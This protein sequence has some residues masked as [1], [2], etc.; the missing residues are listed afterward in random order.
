M[1][2]ADAAPRLA[3]GEL[4]AEKLAEEFLSRIES[5][6]PK[7]NAFITVFGYQALADARKADQEIAAGRYL[8]PLHGIPVS[9]KDLIDVAGSPTTA[10]SLVRRDHRATRDA[11]VTARLRE[12]GAIFVGKTNLH[13]FAFG[14]T[15]EDSG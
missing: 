9:L 2:I 5:L 4:R 8:G 12:A 3:R 14:T 10:A 15:T 11:V 13:A 6:N 1:T 7:L